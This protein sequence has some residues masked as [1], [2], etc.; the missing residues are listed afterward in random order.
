MAPLPQHMS[1]AGQSF[2][3]PQQIRSGFLGCSGN[4]AIKP[5]FWGERNPCLPQL[6]RCSAVASVT[7]VTASPSICRQNQIRRTSPKNLMTP[8]FT[9]PGLAAISVSAIRILDLDHCCGG[10]KLLDEA[11]VNNRSRLPIAWFGL[12]AGVLFENACRPPRGVRARSP[13]GPGPQR[14]SV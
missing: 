12:S 3:H 9:L 2:S 6:S 4:L 11:R 7:E 8:H 10:K 1:S 14:A 13:C 5:S